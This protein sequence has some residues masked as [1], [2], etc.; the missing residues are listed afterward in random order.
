MSKAE[1]KKR[2][3]QAADE[4]AGFITRANDR[5]K[6]ESLCDSL[7]D[8]GYHDYQTCQELLEIAESI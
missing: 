4:L 8:P 2:L 6:I 3:K 7:D 5:L 1:K